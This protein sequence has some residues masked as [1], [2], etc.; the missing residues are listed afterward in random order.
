MLIR[1]K[2]IQRYFTKRLF[3]RLRPMDVIPKYSHRLKMLG[4]C[5]Y[6][7]RAL[8]TDIMLLYRIMTSAVV[9]P[10]F[11]LPSSVSRPNWLIVRRPNC[12]LQ[13]SF[14]AHRTVV[15][16]NRY[17]NKLDLSSPCSFKSSLSS[18]NLS[19]SLRGSAFKAN[20]AVRAF[21]INKLNW[22]ELNWIT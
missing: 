3:C 2:K 13:R 12:S 6:E 4:L 16:W 17:F 22:I 18:L 7:E 20:W 10:G 11:E 14:F 9:V 19:T 15:L 21:E 1:S 8:R 5:S